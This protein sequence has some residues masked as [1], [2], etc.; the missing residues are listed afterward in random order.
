MP[1][2]AAKAISPSSP[3]TASTVTLPP[4]A[5]VTARQTPSANVVA[6]Q[7]PEWRRCVRSWREPDDTAAIGLRKSVVEPVFGQ[8]KQGRGFRQFLLRGVARVQGEWSLICTVHNLLKL[9]K[10]IK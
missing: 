10:S 2:T 8:I 4:G 3:V 7:A 1:D 9:A 6:A 5:N